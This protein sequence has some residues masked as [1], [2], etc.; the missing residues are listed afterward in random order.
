M[1]FVHRQA[2]L[3]GSG[4]GNRWKWGSEGAVGELHVFRLLPAKAWRGP[5][6]PFGD[7]RSFFVSAEKPLSASFRSASARG[8]PIQPSIALQVRFSSSSSAGRPRSA[9][10]SCDRSRRSRCKAQKGE[11]LEILGKGQTRP[12][13]DDSLL[14][15]LKEMAAEV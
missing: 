1:G 3:H 15:L 11:E 13:L 10:S 12:R 5:F 14:E 6:A 9:R 4:P 8:A 7:S 2:W